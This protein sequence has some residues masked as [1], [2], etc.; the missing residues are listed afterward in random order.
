MTAFQMKKYASRLRRRRRLRRLLLFFLLTAGLFLLAERNFR[1]FVFSLAQARCASVASQALS[2]ALADALGD[3]VAYDEL[4]SVRTDE[5]GQVA[6]L[7]ANTVLMNRLAASAGE[8]ALI[9]M[10]QMSSEKISVPLGA[11]L[12]ITVFAG[13]GPGIPVSIVPVGSIRSDFQTEFE[14]CGINQTRHKVYLQ[15]TASIRVV[16]PS[17]LQTTQVSANMLV[18]ESIIVGAVPE[19][20]VGYELSGE[21]LNMVQ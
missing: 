12:G 4:M 7:S 10:Q 5:K 20:F 21:E 18:A 2:R 9:R 16:I 1:P 8:A 3:G 6:L 13:R 14:A 15:L 17:G 19:G 11:A